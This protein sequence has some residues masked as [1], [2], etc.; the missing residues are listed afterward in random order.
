[1]AERRWEDLNCDCLALV[2]ERVG[3]KHLMLDVP[4][5]CK[6]WYK[7]HLSPGCWKNLDFRF[8]N[9]F[10]FGSSYTNL[11]KFAVSR[12]CGTATMVALPNDCTFEDLNYIS[13]EC[14]ALKILIVP[15]LDATPK[16]RQCIP[17]LIAKLNYLENLGICGV[18][19]NKIVTQIGIHCSNFVGLFI[20]SSIH[21][22]EATSIVTNLP[23]I[24]HLSLRNCSLPRECL[25]QILNGCRDLVL[26]DVRGCIGF[27]EDDEEILKLASHI[28][29]FRPQGSMLYDDYYETGADYEDFTGNGSD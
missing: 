3:L 4:L 16:Q 2:F 5:V 13:E 11:I 6:S 25:I 17:E 1:M 28:K 14:K 26:F 12:S 19:L 24:K 7:A 23:K 18:E 9:D 27:D 15:Y 20:N 22:D 29:D 8:A 21:F 10:S